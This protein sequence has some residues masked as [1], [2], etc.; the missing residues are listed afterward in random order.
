[1]GV[2]S[3]HRIPTM[4]APRAPRPSPR[5]GPWDT[6]AA[7]RKE[8]RLMWTPR[9]RGR[10]S[11]GSCTSLLTSMVETS[12]STLLSGPQ[13]PDSQVLTSTSQ[14]YWTCNL[15]C[16]IRWLA[17]CRRFRHL[18]HLCPRLKQQQLSH[19]NHTRG[20]SLAN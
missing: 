20:A 4:T 3:L 13:R 15:V 11:E 9:E 10:G 2:V 5:K 18:Q 17:C 19:T 6:E 16:W 8:V 7:V 14:V 1:M 12:T